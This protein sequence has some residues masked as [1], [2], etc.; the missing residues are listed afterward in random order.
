MLGM[1]TD[2]GDSG[3]V[4]GVRD[5]QSAIGLPEAKSEPSQPRAAPQ[6]GVGCLF[7][8]LKFGGVSVKALAGRTR[9]RA[10][11]LFLS[12]HLGNSETAYAFRV[13]CHPYSVM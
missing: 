2:M 10:R 13:M 8:L 5:T 3:G 4:V 7:R 11:S 9:G 12:Y 6:P 1:Q